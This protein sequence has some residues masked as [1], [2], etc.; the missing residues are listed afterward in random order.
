MS[1]ELYLFCYEKGQPSG[2]PEPA[3][4]G[5]FPILEGK[6][7]PNLWHVYYDSENTCEVAITP[8]SGD[9]ARIESLCIHRPCGD[10]RLFDSLLAILRMGSVILVFPGLESYLAAS[11]AVCADIPKEMLE[12]MG[13]PRLVHSGQEILEVIRS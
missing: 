1:F 7:E 9:P 12:S 2:I 6:S 4:R 13:Q 11:E 10:I 8:A 3:V 5:L